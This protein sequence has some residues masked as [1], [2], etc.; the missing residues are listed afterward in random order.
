MWVPRVFGLMVAVQLLMRHERRRPFPLLVNNPGLDPTRM[1]D[2]GYGPS[3]DA[4]WPL[5]S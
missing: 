5:G 2:V 3:R 1:Q 4:E